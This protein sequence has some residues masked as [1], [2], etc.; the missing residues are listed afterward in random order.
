M[1]LKK[2][3][4]KGRDEVGSDLTHPLSPRGSTGPISTAQA[5]EP[6]DA[7]PGGA[8]RAPGPLAARRRRERPP[9][10]AGRRSR[11]QAYGPSPMTVPS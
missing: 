4:E 8:G 2:E 1:S 11:R 3:E 10:G 6:P 9:G 5:P 7:P